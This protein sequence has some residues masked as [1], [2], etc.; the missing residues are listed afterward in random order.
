MCHAR[1]PLVTPS[2]LSLHA[3]KTTYTFFV[4]LAGLLALLLLA[5]AVRLPA[6][7][8]S[9]SSAS[10]NLVAIEYAASGEKLTGPPLAN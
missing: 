6:D 8:P 5:R 4:R 2:T 1:L 3:V 9:A 10:S 7:A